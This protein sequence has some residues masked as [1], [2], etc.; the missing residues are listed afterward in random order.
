MSHQW[1]RIL[2]V[3]QWLAIIWLLHPWL[4]EA[5]SGGVTWGGGITEFSDIIPSGQ[6]VGTTMRV[7]L[8]H[9][10]PDEMAFIEALQWSKVPGTD[11]NQFTSGGFV[12][13]P[14]RTHGSTLKS[15]VNRM[16]MVFPHRRM[17]GTFHVAS[18]SELSLRVMAHMEYSQACADQSSC[19]P[20]PNLEYL[21]RFAYGYPDDPPAYWGNSV[22][23]PKPDIQ[24]GFDL[25][26]TTHT[27]T[28]ES[29]SPSSDMHVQILEPRFYHFSES[30]MLSH[31]QGCYSPDFW[32]DDDNDSP[33][34]TAA[35]THF[36]DAIVYKF[37]NSSWDV[38]IGNAPGTPC[39]ND[40]FAEDC[41]LT[42]AES[43]KTPEPV[44]TTEEFNGEEYYC[45]TLDLQ[46]WGKTQFVTYDSALRYRHLFTPVP[47]GGL[48]MCLGSNC[49]SFSSFGTICGEE[50]LRHLIANEPFFSSPDPANGR[51][52]WPSPLDSPL[53]EGTIEI[54]GDIVP[55]IQSGDPY[56]EVVG[57]VSLD[58][59]NWGGTKW[60]PPAQPESTLKKYVV[61]V[62]LAWTYFPGGGG[63]VGD[64][65]RWL[66]PNS[67]MSPIGFEQRVWIRYREESVPSCTGADCEAEAYWDLLT[68]LER[69]DLDVCNSDLS[70][71]TPPNPTES[72]FPTIEIVTPTPSL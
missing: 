19:S 60:R 43:M 12:L 35:P 37:S 62:P 3:T 55:A 7:D 28:I 52:A 25:I 21:C 45:A 63:R 66:V 54:L 5:A 8:K 61:E 4:V 18:D 67:L 26:N 22:I 17:L 31:C 30:N 42:V 46:L 13:E 72:P 53:G 10:A 9:S 14:Q 69:E 41:A 48:A 40:Y 16:C 23:R 33:W 44:T 65:V 51:P 50:G 27:M 36:G 71:P 47:L 68:H 15:K 24:H 70:T 39:N 57:A 11:S 64:R 1:I 6:I 32:P 38:C 49:S 58:Y 59:R 34:E 29:N 56:D 2:T 20:P